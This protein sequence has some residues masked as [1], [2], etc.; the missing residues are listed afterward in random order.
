MG[1]QNIWDV[2]LNQ[3]KYEDAKSIY[4]NFSKTLYSIDALIHA[5]MANLSREMM[6]CRLQSSHEHHDRMSL[7]ERCREVESESCETTREIVKS[8]CY[9][10]LEELKMK[11]KAPPPQM[12]S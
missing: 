10:V 5:K 1:A 11:K 6:D 8:I 2:G 9:A 3:Q 4:K 12:Y 7:Y